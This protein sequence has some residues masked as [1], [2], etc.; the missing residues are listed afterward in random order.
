MKTPIHTNTVIPLQTS[1]NA[2]DI[3]AVRYSTP[4]VLMTSS[5]FVNLP[6]VYWVLPSIHELGDPF[7]T[8]Q[9][10]V[11]PKD[12]EHCMFLC[13]FSYLVCYG[14]LPISLMLYLF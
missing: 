10:T 8:S 9:Y 5:G 14:R 2:Q 6:P 1:S 7:L 11:S 13:F 3:E 4:C 12:F